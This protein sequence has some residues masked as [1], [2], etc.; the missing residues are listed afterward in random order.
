MYVTF[1]IASTR[2]IISKLPMGEDGEIIETST[3]KRKCVETQYFGPPNV[4][5][6]RTQTLNK[7]TRN[8]DRNKQKEMTLVAQRAT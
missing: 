4:R 8:G 3:F 1:P 5:I 2:D 6:Q 7:N